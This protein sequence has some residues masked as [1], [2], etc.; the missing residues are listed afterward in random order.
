MLAK[1]KHRLLQKLKT[2]LISNSFAI[3]LFVPE[4]VIF[5]ALLVLTIL[6]KRIFAVYFA[7]GADAHLIEAEQNIHKKQIRHIFAL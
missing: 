1:N 3:Y 4:I 2:T 7:R 6:N 5:R